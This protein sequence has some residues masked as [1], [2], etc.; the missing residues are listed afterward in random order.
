MIAHSLGSWTSRLLALLAL[1]AAACSGGRRGVDAGALPDSLAYDAGEAGVAQHDG[2]MPLAD[3][4]LDADV[5]PSD[6]QV[7]RADAQMGRTD[8]S[9]LED[10]GSPEH[11]AST[12][13]SGGALV[14][15]VN[16]DGCV[17]ASDHQ[18]VL[19]HYGE[20]V[21]PGD[22]ASDVNRDGIVD[23]SDRSLVLQ[24]FGQGCAI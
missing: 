15:D 10:S 22:A 8:A 2:A 18:Q 7:D 19:D 17:D 3:A 14:G 5:G 13:C 9:T 20:S 4:A 24:H 1:S 21:P 11:D 12:P 6:A 23:I 16:C